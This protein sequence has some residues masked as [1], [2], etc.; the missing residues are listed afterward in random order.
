MIYRWKEGKM[1]KHLLILFVLMMVIPFSAFSEEKTLVGDG[2]DNG[3]YGGPVVKFMSLSGDLAVV[4]GGRG[5]WIINHTF[6]IGGGG[7]GLASDIEIDGNDLNLDYGGFE[8]EYIWRSD[9][10]LHFTIH[11]GIGGGKV[12]MIDPVYVQDKFFYLEPTFNLELNLLK[13]LRINTGVGYLW[14]DNIQG[15]PGLSTS[16]VRSVTGTILL[17]FGWF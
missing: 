6:V 1:K 2:F 5:G 4:V 8:L 15:M 14:V 7:Y 12:E 10:L 9:S 17:K 13:W 11:M 3:G 16:D